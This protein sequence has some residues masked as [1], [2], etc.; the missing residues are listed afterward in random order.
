VLEDAA[1][2]DPPPFIPRV[3]EQGGH[4]DFVEQVSQESRLCQ[5]LCLHERRLRLEWYGQ[6]LFKSMKPAWRVNVVERNGENHSPENPAEPAQGSA[7]VLHGAAS[8]D[9]VAQVDGFEQRFQVSGGPR[10]FRRGDQYKW[11]PG[12]LETA[13]NRFRHAQIVDR[14]HPRFDCTPELTDPLE[15]GGDDVR[16]A[17]V[18]FAGEHDNPDA[19]AGKRF[20][21]EMR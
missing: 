16:H 7:T 3:A 11:Q 14:Y 15:Q 21:L 6:K 12:I 1:G 19:R 9:V 2:I 4:L 17:V 5:D 13:A 10:L 8:D 18:R 20:T